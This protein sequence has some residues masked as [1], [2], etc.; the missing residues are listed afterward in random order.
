MAKSGGGT[1]ML[2][3]K[4]GGIGLPHSK[5]R[6]ERQEAAALLNLWI[7]PKHSVPDI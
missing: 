7:Y 6:K 5:K 3:W 1:G 2:G 4:K